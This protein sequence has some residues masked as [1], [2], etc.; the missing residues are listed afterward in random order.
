MVQMLAC[1]VV[2]ARGALLL[3]HTR[4]AWTP[5]VRENARDLFESGV[6]HPS[7]SHLSKLLPAGF[8]C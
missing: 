1:G 3:V 2:R 7:L 5:M 6:Y 8:L 4:P